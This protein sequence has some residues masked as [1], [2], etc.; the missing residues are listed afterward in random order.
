MHGNHGLSRFTTD[1]AVNRDKPQYPWQTVSQT[2]LV[3]FG[4]IFVREHF[5]FDWNFG[6]FFAHNLTPITTTKLLL[7]PLSRTLNICSK[8]MKAQSGLKFPSKLYFGIIN[9]TKAK[10]F[11]FAKFKVAFLKRGQN[12]AG[13]CPFFLRCYGKGFEHR[14]FITV[15]PPNSRLIVSS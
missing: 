8:S 14:Y 4:A 7:G 9:T 1:S 15:V 6:T 12:A 2:L 5:L 10:R 11:V 13:I 3:R